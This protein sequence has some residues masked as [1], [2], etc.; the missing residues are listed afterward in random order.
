MR[1]AEIRDCG[2]SIGANECKRVWEKPESLPHGNSG[3]GCGSCCGTRLITKSSVVVDRCNREAVLP[4]REC[5]DRV[6][7]RKITVRLIRR[8][9]SLRGDRLTH[10][11][12][13]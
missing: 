1:Y 6:M 8:P 5:L 3:F 2:S 11:G 13:S 4:V 7:V 12:R 9:A 10:H